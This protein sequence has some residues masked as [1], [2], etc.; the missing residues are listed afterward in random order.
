MVKDE[1]SISGRLTIELFGKSGE[2][3]ETRDIKN[4]VVSGGRTFIAQS[5][6][7]TSNIPAAMTHIG[8]GTA[9]MPVVNFI[10][11]GTNT[12][13]VT[14][15]STANLATGNFVTIES[16]SGT[17]QSKF[18]G[19]YAIAVTGATT[20]TIVL[21]SSVSVGTYVSS[22]GNLHVRT[23]LNN[24]TLIGQIGSRTAFSSAINTTTS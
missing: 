15:T 20:F 2:L 8:I 22:L 12:G 14:V 9:I 6:L 18:N 10:G 16:A 7:K 13:T 21:S 23:G 3:K 1:I 17:E 5:I 24:S 11:N 4:L 19:T